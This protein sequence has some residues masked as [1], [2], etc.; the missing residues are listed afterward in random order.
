MSAG[1]A[2]AAASIAGGNALQSGINQ[3]ANSYN[4]T[5]NLNSAAGWNNLLSQQGGGYSGYT[6]YTGMN[7]P[8]A[9]LNTRNGWTG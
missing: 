3:A 8:I 9:N 7:D 6:G 1:N 2:Q 4:S 5:N